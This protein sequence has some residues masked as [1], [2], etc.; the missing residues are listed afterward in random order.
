MTAPTQLLA[1]PTTELLS[2]FGAG[3]ASPGSGSAAALMGLLSCRLI[4]TVC[5]KSL[6]KQELKKDHNS[7]S[8]VMSQASDVIYPKLHDLFEKDAKD[9]DEV[10]R[11]RMERDKAT[12]INTKSQLSRQAN[13]LLETTTSNSFEIIDQCFK[14]VDHGI[15]VFGS[16]W[17]A[18]RGDSGA[19]IS[20][21]IAGVTSGIF[22]ANLNLKTLKDRK[23]AGE[24][25]ARC[26]E[27]YKELTHKQTR[28]F[29]CV[30]SLNSEAISAIQLELIK[31]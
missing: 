21:G 19:A 13:D 5:V 23:F 1:K 16:G 24:K 4:I 17:H 28:A 10:V 30:T 31:P 11:L 14:L 25:I 22:I 3:K 29:E 12:N 26:E 20:A 8:Y 15:V 6:E 2:A 7:F 18:V 9:F 27:L